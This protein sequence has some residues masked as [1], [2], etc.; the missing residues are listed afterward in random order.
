MPDDK[1]SD[2]ERQSFLSP[3]FVRNRRDGQTLFLLSGQSNML[4]MDIHSSFVPE[5]LA[6]AQG[7]PFAVAKCARNRQPLSRWLPDWQDLTGLPQHPRDGLML[8]QLLRQAQ[9]VMG[10]QS[11][12]RVVLVWMQGEAD[13]RSNLVDN[14]EVGFTHLVRNLENTLD[15]S[16]DLVVGR[17]AHRSTD[18]P[19]FKTWYRIR[20]LQVDMAERRPGSVWVD[21]DGLNGPDLNTHYSDEGYVELGRRFARA[22]I[23]LGV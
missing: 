19:S 1:L 23:R 22:C 17:L 15:T 13:A 20:E 7:H 21:T 6:H 4:R 10:R 18:S 5:L 2:L 3:G 14:Y 11:P 8:T 12:E 9:S 16:I